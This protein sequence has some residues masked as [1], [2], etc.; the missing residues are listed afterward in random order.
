LGVEAVKCEVATDQLAAMVDNTLN[1][2]PT[3]RR[4]T[5]CGAE[6]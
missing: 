5:N 2:Q 6:A 1:H 3:R 4:F